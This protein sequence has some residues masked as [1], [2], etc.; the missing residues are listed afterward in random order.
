MR[1]AQYIYATVLTFALAG[2]A[3]A[4]TAQTAP[5][6][7]TPAPTQS[8]YGS[9]TDSHWLAS[10]FVGG[11]WNT[12]SDSPRIDTNGTGVNFGGQIAYLWRG[13]VGPEFLANWTP[14]FDV[15]TALVDGS[16][17]VAPLAKG[18]GAAISAA[19]SW[20]SPTVLASAATSG[21]TT[22][23]PLT[24]FQ[25]RR[26]NR[27]SRVFSPGSHT[28]RPA[29]ASAFAGRTGRTARR[30]AVCTT[31]PDSRFAIVSACHGDGPTRFNA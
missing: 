12:T 23:T 27:S 5:P 31:P 17:H 18:A 29:A 7:P 3:A 21:T 28:G 11:G 22:Q 1:S 10:G 19:A 20:H 24:T 16:P 13:Y 2:T 25:G 4:Q 6:R 8:T 30:A 15:T 9:S 14:S 26:T